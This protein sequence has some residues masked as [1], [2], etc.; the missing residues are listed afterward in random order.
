MGRQ[1][2]AVALSPFLRQRLTLLVPKE[3]YSVLDRLTAYIEAGTVTPSIDR[4]LRTR[5][6][7]GRDAATDGWPGARQDHPHH[8]KQAPTR[9]NGV[10][11]I[12]R[13]IVPYAKCHRT[14]ARR[15]SRSAV[16]GVPERR[17]TIW[18]RRSRSDTDRPTGPLRHIPNRT[19]STASTASPGPLTSTLAALCRPKR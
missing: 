2:G 17:A 18:Y 3:H 14:P 11:R 1:L 15:R 8:L 16:T 10:P 4:T 5:S 19:R 7:R 13:P 12:A 9:N 6:G